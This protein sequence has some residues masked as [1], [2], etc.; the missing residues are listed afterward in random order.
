MKNTKKTLLAIG[1]ATLFLGIMLMP[2][3]NA[4]MLEERTVE[5]TTKGDIV[6][7]EYMAEETGNDIESTDCGSIYGYVCYYGLGWTVYY[8]P[9]VLVDA[10]Y[11]SDKTNFLGYYHIDNIPVGET[12]KV[13]VDVMGFEKYTKLVEL[14]PEKPHL[15]VDVEL[16]PDSDSGFLFFHLIQLLL[17][18]IFG[19]F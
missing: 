15:K 9:F 14:S 13:T 7:K 12:I 4:T 10:E 11:G 17:S 5:T 18:I 6:N 8:L 2:C 19:M 16:T 1:A 3:I